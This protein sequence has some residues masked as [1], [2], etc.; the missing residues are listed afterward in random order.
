MAFGKDWKLQT[1]S[2]CSELCPSVTSSAS[3]LCWQRT[4][5][6]ATSVADT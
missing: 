1:S 5:L 3:K 6:S 2:L 4:L